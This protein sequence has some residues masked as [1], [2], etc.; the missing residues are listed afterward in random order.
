MAPNGSFMGQ[1]NS[2]TMSGRVASGHMDAAI[3]GSGCRYGFTGD[4]I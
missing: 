2:G 1:V 3:D 4:R